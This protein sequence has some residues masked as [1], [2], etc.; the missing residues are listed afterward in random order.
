MMTPPTTEMEEAGRDLATPQ[1]NLMQLMFCKETVH[2]HEHKD[3]AI[4]ELFA[5][6]SV[7]HNYFWLI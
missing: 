1:T 3:P 5:L 4:L 7:A 6:R 2:S